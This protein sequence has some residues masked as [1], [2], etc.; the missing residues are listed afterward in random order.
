MTTRSKQTIA[1]TILGLSLTL[2]PVHATELTG[3][4]FRPSIQIGQSTL[5]L[6]G[7]G[8]RQHS[9]VGLYSAGLYLEKKAATTKEVISEL[10]LKQLRM[11]M[12][13][14]TTSKQLIELLNQGLVA[15]NI[16]KNLSAFA[17]E[18]F[19]V[20]LMLGDQGRFLQGDAIEIDSSPTG[21]TTIKIISSKSQAVSASQTF[22][23]PGLF[24][25]MMGVW[26]GERPAD[27]R[28]KSAL[29]GLPN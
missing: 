19:K 5:L 29:L 18:I 12:L 22:T 13:R 10:G 1:L 7:A 20:S 6:N 24:K 8:V 16:D 9:S 2:I 25:V 15:N 17:H 11:V 26:L 14:D 27:P 4:N 21:N 3:A 28:L 23:N